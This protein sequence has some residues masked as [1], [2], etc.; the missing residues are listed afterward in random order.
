M[1]EALSVLDECFPPRR[2]CAVEGALLDE[3]AGDCFPR[4]SFGC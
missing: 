1:R 4:A 3:L 2:R